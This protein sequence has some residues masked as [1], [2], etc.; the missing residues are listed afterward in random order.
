M[1]LELFEKQ[2][3]EDEMDGILLL[4]WQC[5]NRIASIYYYPNL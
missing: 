2:K 5:N 3:D 4:Q 1:K